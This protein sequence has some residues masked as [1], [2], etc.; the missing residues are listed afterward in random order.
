MHV[1]LSE[2]ECTLKFQVSRKHIILV[3]LIQMSVT[4]HQVVQGHFKD[5]KVTLFPALEMKQRWLWDAV[6][7]GN[8][9]FRVRWWS[10]CRTGCNLVWKQGKVLLDWDMARLNSE[11]S[12]VLLERGNPEGSRVLLEAGMVV[13]PGTGCGAAGCRTTG[14]GAGCT[15]TG[16]GCGTTRAGAG[17][18]NLK[19]NF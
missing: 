3:P 1:G 18:W 2:L 11:G 12:S 6:W 19:L 13:N 16:A 7:W 10:R 4:V 9:L 8:Q 5:G 14:T 15:T 17:C